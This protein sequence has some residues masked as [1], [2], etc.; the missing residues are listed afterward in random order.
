MRNHWRNRLVVGATL[1]GCAS[2][3]G[4]PPP[5]TSAA[6]PQQ[7]PSRLPLF[8]V[9]LVDDISV[10]DANPYQGGGPLGGKRFF[11]TK[12]VG[13]VNSCAQAAS[14]SV[15]AW[16]RTNK[17]VVEKYRIATDDLALS[18]RR[19]D[20]EGLLEFSYSVTVKGDTTV[21]LASLFYHKLDGTK[22]EPADLQ[23][24]LTES[25]VGMLQD[26]LTAAID[27]PGLEHK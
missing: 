23:P 11:E 27:C 6:Q 9:A 16:A 1:V 21:A 8:A 22:V 25:D 19:N 18:L 5:S 7:S 24:H 2:P 12:L 13:K 3:S 10:R 20:L 17:F 26:T 4:G 15:R 14:S